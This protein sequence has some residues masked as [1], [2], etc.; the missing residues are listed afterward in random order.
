[1]FDRNIVQPIKEILDDGRLW[2][3][4]WLGRLTWN[5]N[6]PDE[7]LIQVLISPLKADTRLHPKDLASVNSVEREQRSIYIGTGQLPYLRIG[8]L[9]QKGRCRDTFAGVLGGVVN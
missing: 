9:W 4:D 6:I 8:S 2:R 7:P 5:P 3:I 1:M